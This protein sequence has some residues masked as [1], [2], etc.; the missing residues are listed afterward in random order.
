MT[1][2]TIGF[3]G[4]PA[5][6]LSALEALYHSPHQL[7]AIYTQPDRPAG[8][9]RKLHPSVIKQFATAHDIPCFQP[10]NFKQE[11]DIETLKDLNLDVLVV[12]AYG[13]IL[14]QRVLST[15]RYGCIN[16]H[17]SLLPRWRG[18]SPIQQSILHGDPKTG[19][20]IMQMDKG[21]DTGDML[22]SAS[23]QITETDTSETLHDK[24]AQ[25]AIEP[26][27][28]TLKEISI[29]QAHPQPQSDDTATYAPKI[30]KE[31]ALLKWN[32]P[33]DMIDRKIRA[34]QPWPVAY[35]EFENQLIRVHEAQKNNQI[36]DAQPGTIINI[37][38][39]GIF[40]ATKTEV[41]QI[42][43]LQS[44]GGKVLTA[45]EWMQSHPAIQVG[46]QLT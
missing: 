35:T 5:F 15:P 37:D 23:L 28:K 16:V 14:P 33:A 32:E 6:G 40:V 18:A 30:T 3:A 13:L 17:A 43:R 36:T 8:R 27:L 44:P 24:L 19:V 9:G 29:H 39:T 26:L 31:E 42:T 4:T 7:K 46:A 25:L 45:R 11:Q 12:I 34:Y 2:L 1:S 21:L 41:I 22:N 10:E 20:T 38:K